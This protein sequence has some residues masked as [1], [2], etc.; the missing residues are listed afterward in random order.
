MRENNKVTPGIVYVDG[1]EKT[2]NEKMYLVLLKGEY[3]DNEAKEYRDF[4]WVIGRQNV[5]EYI[6]DLILNEEDT[7]IDIH[8]SKI[9][10]ETVNIL[11]A[12][13]IYEFMKTFKDIVLDDTGFDIEEYNI[14]SE[15]GI[16]EMEE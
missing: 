14:Q 15:I 1:R 16:E 11:D 6:R 3:K 12:I 9:I 8:E 2:P 10:A 13:S 5:Y 7:C 4:E